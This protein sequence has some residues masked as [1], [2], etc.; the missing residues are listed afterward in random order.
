LIST[1]TWSISLNPF[2]H[3]PLTDHE[4]Q[5]DCLCYLSYTGKPVKASRLFLGHQHDESIA[6]LAENFH[7]TAEQILELPFDEAL[8]TELINRQPSDFLAEISAAKTV[9]EAYHYV[10]GMLMQEQKKSTD[11]ILTE[12]VTTIY[13]DGGFSN[14]NLY[15][16][17]LKKLYPEHH[18]CAAELPQASALGAAL[19]IHDSW[20]QQSRSPMLV[21]LID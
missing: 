5:H 10:I 12:D 21:T 2:N 20:N 17:M 13:V 19:V 6:K 9:S 7:I 8:A 1:G 14:N 18:V 3:L 16:P 4:L 15:M 11:L